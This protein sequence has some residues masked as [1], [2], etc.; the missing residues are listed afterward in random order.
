[1]IANFNEQPNIRKLEQK[2]SHDLKAF[3]R[4]SPVFR[5]KMKMMAWY[6]DRNTEAREVVNLTQKRVH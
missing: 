1:L 6:E 3:P 2:I 5:A 4:T